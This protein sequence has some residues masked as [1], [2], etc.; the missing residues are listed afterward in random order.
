MDPNNPAVARLCLMLVEQNFGPIVHVRGV[1]ERSEDA[2]ARA[3]E[4]ETGTNK[5]ALLSSPIDN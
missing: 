2:R 3:R 5:R 4:R 1:D